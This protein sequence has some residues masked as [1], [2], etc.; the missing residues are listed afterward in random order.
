MALIELAVSNLAVIETVRL[1]LS[2]G[3]VVVTGETGAGKSLV[4]DA[5]ALAL[6]ARGASELIRSRASSQRAQAA[7]L[8][9]DPHELQRRTE[10]LRHQV[11]E[12][13]ATALQPDEDSALTA[14]LKA[15]QNLETVIRAVADAVRIIQ[16][17]GGALDAL[18]AAQAQLE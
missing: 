11:H 1:R 6:G 2:R 10:L 8:L 17:E 18:R 16:R 14:H 5:L 13:E 7:E 15:V 12:I 3:F 9:T 4:V